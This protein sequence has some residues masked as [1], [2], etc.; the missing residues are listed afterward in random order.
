[1][2]TKQ[3]V[4]MGALIPPWA[5]SSGS[6]CFLAASRRTAGEMGWLAMWAAPA[7]I[8]TGLKRSISAFVGCWVIGKRGLLRN[9]CV[10]VLVIGAAVFPSHPR[11]MKGCSQL[12]TA[13]IFLMSSCLASPL[14]QGKGCALQ[15]RLPKVTC[16]ADCPHFQSVDALKGPMV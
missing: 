11:E 7:R 13:N 4:A 12:L 15:H 5:L 1:M 9:G 6:R 10:M 16:N 2:I 8:P 3:N 14:S